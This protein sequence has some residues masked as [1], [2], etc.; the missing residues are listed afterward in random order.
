M[1]RTAAVAAL[2]AAGAL[3]LLGLAGCGGTSQAA[4]DGTTL[5]F[6]AIP[7]EQS[8]DA[9]MKYGNLTKLLQKRTGRQ[10]KFVKST[11]Y[12]AVIEGMVSGR[13]D[14]AEFGPLSYVLAKHNG[15]KITPVVS[16]AP[17][18]APATY[19]SY[20]LVPKGSPVTG[21][22]GFRGKKVCFVDPSS[23]SGYL[24]PTAQL[25]KSGLN[26]QKDI[27]PIFAGGHDTSALSVKSG[28]CD[29][30]FADSMMVDQILP[31][32]GAIKKGD[33]KVVWKSTPIPNDPLT[34]RDDLPADVRKKIGDALV[35]DANKPGLVRLGIC[36]NE[37][38][39]TITSD[40]TI[41]G[42]K[43]VTDKTFDPI[44][45]VCAATQDKQCTSGG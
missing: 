6:A 18:N 43:P 20:G 29:V 36:K 8:A 12:N 45:T 5:T 25:K 40:T 24:F 37:A 35:R 1:K 21:V 22:A 16:L 7:S 10:V 9:A 38:T 13:I 2:V 15:A 42:T 30:G 11:N 39:C 33:L 4:D 32:K 34:V 41:W 27:T 44:R 26:P 28:K 23:T 17:K 19:F 3:S 14:V 31:G